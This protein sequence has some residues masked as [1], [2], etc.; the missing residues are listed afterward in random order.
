MKVGKPC[1]STPHC[2]WDCIECCTP[3]KGSIW[4]HHFG[5]PSIRSS[6]RWHLIQLLTSCNFSFCINKQHLLLT[7]WTWGMVSM[8]PPGFGESEDGAILITALWFSHFKI[9]EQDLMRL[10]RSRKSACKVRWDYLLELTLSHWKRTHFFLLC[11]NGEGRETV[12]AVFHCLPSISKEQ[13]LQV[14]KNK[15]DTT[16]IKKDQKTPTPNL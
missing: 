7:S 16:N 9:Y 3:K 2:R 12:P 10:S 8:N 14:P 6:I 13:S 11:I 5:A 4:C 15:I 1:L